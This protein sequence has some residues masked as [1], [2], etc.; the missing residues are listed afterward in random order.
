MISL[1]FFSLSYSVYVF[2]CLLYGTFAS[3]HSQSFRKEKWKSS[4]C[5]LQRQQHDDVDFHPHTTSSFFV[6]IGGVIVVVAVH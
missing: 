4:L 5:R 2:F 3:L 6:L 1:N